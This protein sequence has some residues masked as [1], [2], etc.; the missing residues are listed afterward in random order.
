MYIER[1]LL[2]YLRVWFQLSKRLIDLTCKSRFNNWMS[3]LSQLLLLHW[4][5][6]A[7]VVTSTERSVHKFWTVLNWPWMC[8]SCDLYWTECSHVL[9]CTELVLDVH[10]LLSLLNWVYTSLNSYSIRFAQS[11]YWTEF[12]QVTTELGLHKVTTEL[13]LHKVTTELGLPST[14]WMCTRLYSNYTLLYYWTECR[15]YLQSSGLSV[16]Y[17]GNLLDRVSVVSAIFWTECRLYQHSSGLS[18]CCIST[19]LDRVSVVSAIFWTECLLYQHSSGLSVCCIGNLLDRVSV[20]SEI[21]WTECLLYRQSSG[22]SVCCI[23]NL[24]DRVSVVSTIFWTECQSCLYT[25]LC[26]ICL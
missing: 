8:A 4:L 26:I 3:L 11:N 16:G 22:Q 9:N 17:I 12:A 14:A 7:Q 25:L 15:L 21:F 19:L 23:G 5:V 13:S 2:C 18:V 24:L 10:K 1:V 20:V 6:C